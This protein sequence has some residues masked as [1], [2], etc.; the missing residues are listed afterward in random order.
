MLQL[1][2]PEKPLF[3]PSER[4]RNQM[5]NSEMH[6]MSINK[7]RFPRTASL[8]LNSHNAAA[9]SPQFFV[10]GTAGL[11]RSPWT[12]NYQKG[13]NSE[14]VPLTTNVRHRYLCNG[15]ALPM[16]WEDAERWIGSPFSVD[17]AGRPALPSYYKRPKSKSGP[18][19]GHSPLVPCFDRGRV[20]NVAASSPFLAG[21]LVADRQCFGSARGEAGGCA[22]GRVISAHVE[23]YVAQ[24]SAAL[25][26]WSDLSSQDT[27]QGCCLVSPLL[28]Y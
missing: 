25:H 24:Q 26:G 10:G 27:S 2:R 16:K 22:G 14:R 11:K 4:F 12:P 18:L 21:V 13:W 20:V 8:D 9:L 3:F 19:G 23:S 7:Q 17:G 6:P 1:L 28:H 15:K 5:A